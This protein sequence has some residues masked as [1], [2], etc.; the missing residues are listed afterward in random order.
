MMSDKMR[1]FLISEFR[2]IEESA[3]ESVERIHPHDKKVSIPVM[4]DGVM[5]TAIYDSVSHKFVAL[6]IFM[7]DDP[8]CSTFFGK[9]AA[10]VDADRIHVEEII[11]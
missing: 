6:H 8:S 3:L 4:L 1:E 11:L 7:A 9:T 10:W 2:K 5:D